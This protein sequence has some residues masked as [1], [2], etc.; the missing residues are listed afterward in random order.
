[1]YVLLVPD[2]AIH[3]TLSG[4]VGVADIRVDVVR[5]GRDAGEQ[6]L[7]LADDVTTIGAGQRSVSGAVDGRHAFFTVDRNVS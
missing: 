6:T 3:L 5:P 2:P 7:L 4:V 1:M